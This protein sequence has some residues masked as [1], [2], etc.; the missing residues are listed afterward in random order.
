MNWKGSCWLVRW[1]SPFGVVYMKRMKSRLVAGG[2][3]PEEGARFETK[4]KAEEAAT[5]LVASAP[6]A[7]IGKISVREWDGGKRYP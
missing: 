7:L 5:L 6:D 4:E 1:D 3:H 2:N